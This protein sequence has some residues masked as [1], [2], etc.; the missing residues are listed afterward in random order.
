MMDT[1]TK[2]TGYPL[3]TISRSSANLLT[4]KQ[5][6][7]FAVPHKDT[8]FIPPSPYKYVIHYAVCVGC[9]VFV[10]YPCA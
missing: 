6:R 2:Q 5:E 8:D 7:F 3:L 9:V 4:I 1:W 10:L